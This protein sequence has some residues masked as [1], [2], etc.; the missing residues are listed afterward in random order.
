MAG[1]RGDAFQPGQHIPEHRPD[2]RAEDHGGGNDILVDDPATYRFGDVETDDPV[3]REVAGRGKDHRG[4]GRK[5]LGRDNRGDRI[6][7][8]VQ[9]VE[10]IERQR[11][12]DQADEQRKGELVHCFAALF[13]NVR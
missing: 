8:I 10:E 1:G 9:A 5:Q 3:G 2:E 11:H 6:G 7:G 13:T 12:G 4:D